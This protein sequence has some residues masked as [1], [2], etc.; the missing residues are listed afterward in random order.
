MANQKMKSMRTLESIDVKPAWL[1]QRTSKKSKTP[2]NRAK[3]VDKHV[4]DHALIHNL[5]F[6]LGK[7]DTRIASI[8]VKKI[9]QNE[10]HRLL[11]GAR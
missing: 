8:S 6:A 9:G 1:I 3:L 10:L 7:G 4:T 2:F 5:L 11:V